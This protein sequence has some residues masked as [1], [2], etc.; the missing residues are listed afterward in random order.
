MNGTVSTQHLVRE[1]QNPVASLLSLSFGESGKLSSPPLEPMNWRI[2]SLSFIFPHL[3]ISFPFMPYIALCRHISRLHRYQ[4]K[5]RIPK[6][7]PGIVIQMSPIRFYSALRTI[8]RPLWIRLP[9]VWRSIHQ[10][11]IQTPIRI[12]PCTSSLPCLEPCLSSSF[13]HNHS[14]GSNGTRFHR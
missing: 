2:F 14:N 11:P 12:P 8:L 3:F 13:T 7:H 5:S 10:D 1:Y 9:E 6:V 4:Y